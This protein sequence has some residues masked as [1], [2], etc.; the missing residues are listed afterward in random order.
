M[1]LKI[2]GKDGLYS[3]QGSSLI[4]CIFNLDNKKLSNKILDN[5]SNDYN[6]VKNGW[7]KIEDLHHLLI[8][9]CIYN[10]CD[11]FDLKYKIED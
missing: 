8:E 6:T 2:Y 11:D 1:L 3:G 10:F 4:K 5:I 9:G 7:T